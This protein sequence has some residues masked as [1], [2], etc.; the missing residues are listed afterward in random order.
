MKRNEDIGVFTEPSLLFANIQPTHLFNIG[1]L[2][3]VAKDA[4]PV[5]HGQ[6]VI[7]PAVH[8]VGFRPVLENILAK[9]GLVELLHGLLVAP[10]AAGVVFAC[11]VYGVVFRKGISLGQGNTHE[12][13]YENPTITHF[14]V[15]SFPAITRGSARPDVEQ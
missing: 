2:N 8:P 1:G 10:G 9:L 6:L 14:D 11:F 15:L 12:S 3:A 7:A 4:V 5:F 13:K